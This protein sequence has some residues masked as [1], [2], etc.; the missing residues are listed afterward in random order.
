MNPDAEVDKLRMTKAIGEMPEP[1]KSK[2]ATPTRVQ[3][4]RRESVR[5]STVL[6][7]KGPIKATKQTKNPLTTKRHRKEVSLDDSLAA[8]LP[9]ADNLAAN[10]PS[11]G[12]LGTSTGAAATGFTPGQEMMMS[13]QPQPTQGEPGPSIP[14]AT[15]RRSIVAGLVPT[16]Q[17]RAGT[18]GLQPGNTDGQQDRQV[19]LTASLGALGTMPAL[20]DALPVARPLNTMTGSLGAT[21]FLGQQQSTIQPPASYYL[22][23]L[24]PKFNKAS[25]LPWFMRFEGLMSS[26]NLTPLDKFITLAALVPTDL[27]NRLQ[28]A[29]I[30]INDQ[31]ANLR[32]D[33]LKNA[34]INCTSVTSAERSFRLMTLPYLGKKAPSELMTELL[35]LVYPPGSFSTDNLHLFLSRLPYELARP[36]TEKTAEDVPDPM[37]FALK[38][39][40]D[41]EA[42][43]N[44]FRGGYTQNKQLR[45]LPASNQRA[46]GQQ[47]AQQPVQTQGA[48]QNRNQ[49]KVGSQQTWRGSTPNAAT[50]PVQGQSELCF[51]HQR[52]GQNART[53]VEGCKWR[54]ALAI[55]HQGVELYQAE[56]GQY[57][58]LQ[59]SM[60]S[61]FCSITN[62]PFFIDTGA[63]LSFIPVYMAQQRK[64]TVMTDNIKTVTVAD[65]GEMAVDGFVSLH[66]DVGTGPVKWKFYI[67][68]VAFPILGRDFFIAND[69][70]IDSRIPKLFK[71]P[72]VP[73]CNTIR[74]VAFEDGVS[75][76]RLPPQFQQYQ[77]IC[78][79][80]E[81]VDFTRF[82]VLQTKHF[83]R[84]T[85]AP[86]T[87]KVRRLSLE[88]F[89]ALKVCLKDM[90]DDGIIRPSASPWSSPITMVK[91]SDGSW[92]LCGDYRVLNNVTQKDEY[93]IPNILDV[94]NALAGK[95]IFSRL[96]L[97]K[98]FWQVPMAEE[99][100]QKTAITTPLGLFEFLRMPFGLKNS[101]NTFQRTVDNIFRDVQDTFVYVDDVLVASTDMQSHLATLNTVFEK[102][103]ENGLGITSR[104]CEFFQSTIKFLGYNLS[105]DGATPPPEKVEAL[106]KVP[107]PASPKQMQSFLGAVNFFRRFYKNFAHSAIHL[108]RAANMLPSN[109]KV[110]WDA[111]V[112]DS[113]EA[114]K[115]IIAEKTI[116]AHPIPGASIALTT[117]ASDLAMGATL[118]QLKDGHWQPLA[119]FSRKWKPAQIKYGAYDKE[120]TAIVEAI[121]YFHYFV[122]GNKFTIYTDH[123]PLIAGFHK[124][125][126]PL[127]PMQQ[128]YLSFI[129]EYTEDIRHLPGKQNVIADML[130][131]SLMALHCNLDDHL[132]AQ[133]IELQQNDEEL[134]ALRTKYPD[135]FG[136]EPWKDRQV[137]GDKSRAFRI[138]VPGPLREQ[139][140]SKIH[141]LAHPGI[142]QTKVN[143][144]KSFIWAGMD[145]SV[146][147]FVRACAACQK[148]KVGKQ[149]RRPLL[150]FPL[151]NS[152]FQHIHVDYVGPLPTSRNYKYLFTVIDRYSRYPVAVPVTSPSAKVAIDTLAQRWIAHFGVPESITSDCGPAFRSDEF[153][154]YLKEQ[155]IEWKPT[156]T[157]HPQSNGLVERLHR[158]LKE[159]LVADGRHWYDSL[160]WVLLAIRN[161]KG[162]DIAYSPNESLFG[163]NV[164][165]PNSIKVI[166]QDLPLETFTK[167]RMQWPTP[168]PQ[169]G[170]WHNKPRPTNN[171]DLTGV[172]YVLVRRHQKSPMQFAYA[173]PF[174]LRAFTD[175]TAE[176]SYYNKTLIISRDRIK[177]IFQDEGK[178]HFLPND[179]NNLLSIEAIDDLFSKGGGD[180]VAKA[181]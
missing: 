158:R 18:M 28:H 108:Y 49:P 20:R 96:D 10:R 40:R 178:F 63:S 118:E 78:G 163:E 90:L 93:P 137:I 65:G 114:V 31:P 39:D 134:K 175:K 15:P 69:L 62:I 128:R 179:D 159:A 177:P 79:D 76:K 85:G 61:I 67:T 120:L 106:L 82:K 104:K 97:I 75:T 156:T 139:I 32:Y 153:R 123:K 27:D 34:L 145:A 3:P 155:N 102:L 181:T 151:P 45:V 115:R 112:R 23:S 14:V 171:I 46:P 143:V 132:M 58:P 5:T 98:G 21:P 50:T 2:K 165:L 30:S 36:H 103:R 154:Q 166:T 38:L 7:R 92:R 94:Q 47:A 42:S 110:D 142:R 68:K 130:S 88:R 33:L 44:R 127:S 9:E 160:P 111:D 19:A 56:D 4:T 74:A 71:R 140:V 83:I 99:D 86:C 60:N 89:A 161:A 95:V 157:Y 116:L 1:K 66:I 167:A 16:P 81:G 17:V 173:G 54:Q 91:K 164:R 24:V 124:K 133:I 43:R 87:T 149:D 100:V 22:T 25:P 51:Y 146:K 41:L 152:R 144:A 53:C 147:K 138:F 64:Y 77:C 135:R 48:S 122:D 141:E 6:A 80:M 136:P 55:Q 59:G 52:F 125:T 8:S 73:Q 35:T 126:T 57:F 29:W 109:K 176:I 12:A 11:V 129:S 37:S 170:R 174:P 105:K 121:K 119:Y 26:Y 168:Q 13:Q 107:I 148:A 180:V 117:D 162:P 101:P 150:H 131:R 172:R 113:F 84:T 72:S 70:L 169:Q